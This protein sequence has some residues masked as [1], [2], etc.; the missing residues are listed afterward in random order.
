[1]ASAASMVTENYI[2]GWQNKDPTQREN[3][4]H[5]HFVRMHNEVEQNGNSV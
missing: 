5:K 4:Q 3:S 2:A 1:M